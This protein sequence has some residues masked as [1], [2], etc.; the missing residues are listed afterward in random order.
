MFIIAEEVDDSPDDVEEVVEVGDESDDEGGNSKKVTQKVRK[1]RSP[2]TTFDARTEEDLIEWFKDHPE[3][4]NTKLKL[5]MD[6]DHK[7]ALYEAKAKEVGLNSEFCN[8]FD[9]LSFGQCLFKCGQHCCN[10]LL[11]QV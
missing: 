6:K 4:Y 3:F 9:I 8:T 2:N 11:L 5:H 1:P 10:V 7:E